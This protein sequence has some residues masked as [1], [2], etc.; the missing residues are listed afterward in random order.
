MIPPTHIKCR[1]LAFI[2]CL[3]S[4]TTALSAQIQ[5]LW[6]AAYF[7]NKVHIS[8]NPKSI[9]QD[10]ILH[11]RFW[12]WRYIDGHGSK[13]LDMVIDIIPYFDM[14]LSDLGLESHRKNNLFAELFFPYGQKDYIGLVQEWLVKRVLSNGKI[15][16]PPSATKGHI[17]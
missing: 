16:L 3:K 14:L 15:D 10:T 17:D 13:F 4:V 5:G 1:D 11:N 9:Q 8:L 2:G 7:D 6:I 12:Q